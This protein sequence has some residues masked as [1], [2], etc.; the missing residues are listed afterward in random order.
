MAETHFRLYPRGFLGDLNNNPIEN[1][2]DDGAEVLRAIRNAETKPPRTAMVGAP[3]QDIGILYHEYMV[4]PSVMERFAWR[5]K[6][7]TVALKAFGTDSLALW[8]KAQPTSPY[9]GKRHRDFVNDCL[10]FV[11]GRQRTLALS[12]WDMIISNDDF[13]SVASTGTKVKDMYDEYAGNTGS[14]REHVSIVDLISMW[15]GCENGYSDLLISLNIMFGR[16]SS[17]T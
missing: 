4:T 9:F 16:P 13:S 7:L 14:M 10:L 17:L 5:E 11:N 2:R 3:N 15:C 12:S 6:L 1:K 8:L